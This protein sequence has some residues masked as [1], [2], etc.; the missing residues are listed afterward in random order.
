MAS[1]PL[2]ASENRGQMATALL[3]SDD[4]KLLQCSSRQSVTAKTSQCEGQ[5]FERRNKNK[6]GAMATT[7]A[8]TAMAVKVASALVKKGGSVQ[9]SMHDIK[10]NIYIWT[11]TITNDRKAAAAGVEM[12]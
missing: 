4:I 7:L 3:C 5:F 6:P 9:S 12:G 11:A 10:N 8:N 2:L 1:S